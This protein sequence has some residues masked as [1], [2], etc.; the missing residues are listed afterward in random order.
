MN[1]KLKPVPKFRNEAEERRFWETH[2][3]QRLC[4]LERVRAGA[5]AKSQA[6]NDLDFPASAGDTS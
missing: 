4:R 1:T 6:V 2:E 5:L 3:L